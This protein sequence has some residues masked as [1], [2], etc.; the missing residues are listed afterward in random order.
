MR[1]K[2]RTVALTLLTLLLLSVLGACGQPAGPGDLFVEENA[3]TTSVPVD[4][5]MIGADEFRRMVGAGQLTLRSTVDVDD[6]VASRAADF[7]SN[8]ALLAGLTNPSAN[9]T[10]LLAATADASAYS[11]DVRIA[12]GG[13]TVRLEGLGTSLANA[14]ASAQLATSAANA[15]SAY[16]L[17]YDLVPADLRAQL[18]TP[19][20]LQGAAIGAIDAALDQLNTLLETVDNLDLTHVEAVPVAPGYVGLEPQSAGAGLDTD[21]ACA[22]PSNFASRLWFPLKSFISPIRNQANR[23]TC[24]A[25]TAIGAIE[26]RELVQNGLSVN[27]SEQFLVNKVKEDW[28]SEDYS[29]G[30][31]A[32]VALNTAVSKGQSLPNE[33]SWTYNGSPN[34]ASTKDGSAADFAG[35]CN[36][37]GQGPNAGWCSETAHQS[38]TYCTTF[39]FTFC[40]YKTI[41]FSGAGVPASKAV[42]VWSSGQ[43]F[44][45]ANYRNLLAQGHVLLAS[46]P[47]YEGFMTAAGGVVTDYSKQYRNGEGDLVDGSYGGHA[48]QIVAF[49]SNEQLSTPS[50]TYNIGGGGYFLVK[51]SWGCGSGDGGYWYVPADYVRTRFNSL[52]VMQFDTRRSSRWTGEQANPGSTEAPAVSIKIPSTTIDLRVPK[53]L[54]FSFGV[55]HSVAASVNLVVSS[56]VDGTLYSGA[57]NTAPYSFPAS[58]VRTFTSVGQRT[59]TVKATYAG[60]VT[61]RTFTANVVN[62]APTIAFTGGPTAYQGEAYALTANVQDINDAGTTGLCSRMTWTV[63]APDTLT[64]TSGCQVAVTFGTQGARTVTATTTDADGLRTTRSTTLNVQPPPPNPYPRVTAFGMQAREFRDLGGGAYFCLNTSVALGATIRLMDNGCRFVGET[65]DSRRHSAYVTVEN[66]DNETLAYDWRLYVYYQG[67][68]HPI[69]STIGSSSSDWVPGMPGNTGEATDPCYVSVTVR[70]PEAARNKSLTVWTGSCT[71]YAIRLN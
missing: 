30:Y 47:V 41:T 52:D 21:A 49:L 27:L 71:Y 36:P 9:V 28:D 22:G 66:P 60:N 55:S 1:T 69:S 56:S 3:W 68:Y 54:A 40:G 63:T 8:R 64:P 25:F 59:I 29:E 33:S 70:A 39:V 11:G 16:Q 6:Q 24:W 23:G 61:Q 50:Y 44:N 42:Q 14:A 48:V 45:L 5:T 17:S 19:A 67:A 37:Y 31:N 46:F 38:P 62:S 10:D 2:V 34:R 32:R 7:A 57:W 13:A 15:L 58:L 51:N 4:A 18:P 65:T 43:A 20:S 26:S 12:V 35:A 53:D